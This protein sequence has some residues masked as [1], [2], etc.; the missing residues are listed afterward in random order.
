MG[1]WRLHGQPG[2]AAAWGG[3]ASWGVRV[4]AV[5]VLQPEGIAAKWGGVVQ[6]GAVKT[7]QQQKDKLQR[8]LGGAHEY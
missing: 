1:W 7:G 4:G 3:W 6:L 2:Q 8:K 5:P